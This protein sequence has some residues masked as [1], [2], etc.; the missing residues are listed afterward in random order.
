M[1][2]EA[3]VPTFVTIVG[4]PVIGLAPIANDPVAVRHVKK[5]TLHRAH[6]VRADGLAGLR[7]GDGVTRRVT[8]PAV[9][10]VG[11]YVSLTSVA[12]VAVAIREA[13]GARRA[14]RSASGSVAGARGARG[15]AG[16]AIGRIADRVGLAP[17]ERIRVAVCPSNVAVV[18]AEELWVA[19]ALGCIAKRVHM[20]H[21]A[22]HAAVTTIA[23]H[24]N[25]RLTSV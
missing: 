6:S 1:R 21:V 19:I 16:A 24:L 7:I 20:G 3:R 22:C 17:V 13:R 23:V 25:R 14:G 12:G 10:Q 15:V 5:G 8:C 18:C 11:P 4:I 2:P 9:V